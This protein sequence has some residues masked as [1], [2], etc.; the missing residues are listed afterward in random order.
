MSYKYK[1]IL[2]I[3]SLNLGGAERQ[4]LELARYIDKTRFE[5]Y[6]CTMYGGLLEDEVQLLSNVHYTNLCKK[7]R[8]DIS[9]FYRYHT[10]LDVIKPD[11]IYSFLPEMNLFSL[12]CKPSQSKLIWGIRASNMHLD[13]YGMTAKFVLHMQKYCSKWVDGIITNSGASIVYHT[14]LGFA[15]QKA[16]VVHNGIDSTRFVASAQQREFFR[17]QYGMND[18]NIVVV[19]LIGRID[20]IKGHMTFARVAKRILEEQNQFYF[21]VIGSGD[22][23]I[24][25][26]CQLILGQYNQTRFIWI[27]EMKHIENGYAGLDI[28][29]STSLSE[30]FSN[31][32]A[33]AMSSEIPCIVTDVGDSRIIVGECGIVIPYEDERALYDAIMDMSKSDRVILGQKSRKRIEDTFSISNMVAQTETIIMGMLNDDTN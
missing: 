32:I 6:I 15:M 33:E 7:G 2:S 28:L 30:S 20:I 26:E 31:S 23:K 19:G 12:W 9:F 10:Y 17:H 24:K 11:I 14:K 21:V 29:C 3:R 25:Q 1:I 5:L 16:S 13:N 8:F 22:K 18:N 27:D 4:F